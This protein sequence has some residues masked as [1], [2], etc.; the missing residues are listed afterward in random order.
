MVGP[1][2]PAHTTAVLLTWFVWRESAYSSQDRFPDSH[3][4]LGVNPLALLG[5]DPLIALAHREGC[6][7]GGSDPGSG[8]SG[9]SGEDSGT[10][11]KSALAQS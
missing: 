2:G 11:G 8:G 4:L 1:V 5:D 10:Q 3:G 9:D 6:D 7:G